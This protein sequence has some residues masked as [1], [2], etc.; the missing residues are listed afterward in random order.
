[1]QSSANDLVVTAQ[2]QAQHP[3]FSQG[4]AF[5]K[6]ETVWDLTGRTVN[7]IVNVNDPAGFGPANSPNGAQIFL[8]DANFKSYYGSWHNLTS[9]SVSIALPPFAQASADAY[10]DPGFDVTKIVIVGVKIGTGSQADA[11]YAYSGTFIISDC[12]IR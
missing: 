6:Y 2:L 8:K 3:N 4:E 5:A 11:N 9:P 10:I 12:S 7:C 1:V